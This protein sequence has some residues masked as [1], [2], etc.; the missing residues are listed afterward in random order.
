MLVFIIF[1]VYCVPA[2]ILSFGMGEIVMDATNNVY[3]ATGTLSFM[4]ALLM[5]L[6]YIVR[7]LWK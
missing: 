2:F 4:F 3:Q 1:L 6:F 7:R 5:F